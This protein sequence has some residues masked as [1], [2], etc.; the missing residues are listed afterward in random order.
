[1]LPGLSGSQGVSTT[2]DDF[3]SLQSLW[4]KKDEE[5]TVKVTCRAVNL[6]SKNPAANSDLAFS[7][8]KELKSSPLFDEKVTQL[9]GQLEAVDSTADTFTFQVTLKLKRVIKL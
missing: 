9:S 8:E 5:G 4:E 7:L 3:S 6:T 1:M 2:Y